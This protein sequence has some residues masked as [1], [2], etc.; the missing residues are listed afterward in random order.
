MA[1]VPSCMMLH[2]SKAEQAE[3]EALVETLIG[4]LDKRSDSKQ[5]FVS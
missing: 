3:M 1:G 4:A 2:E 5:Q